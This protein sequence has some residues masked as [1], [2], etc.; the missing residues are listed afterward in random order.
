MSNA[1]NACCYVP[2]YPGLTVN[3][4]KRALSKL[5]GMGYPPSK[6]TRR[7]SKKVYRWL[8]MPGL[9]LHCDQY[10]I[11][12]L[13][14]MNVIVTS[15]TSEPLRSVIYLYIDLTFLVG[16]KLF[17]VLYIYIYKYVNYHISDHLSYIKCYTEYIISY[18]FA[19]YVFIVFYILQYTMFYFVY[20]RLY[21]YDIVCCIYI[22]QYI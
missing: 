22:Y 1:A 16:N 14:H 19:C 9:Q 13:L 18:T 4:A 3:F 7:Y 5:L 6:S 15:F 8:I 10:T 21:K 17:H 2:L 11:V 20:H 12:Q